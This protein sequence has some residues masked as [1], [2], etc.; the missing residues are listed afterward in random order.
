MMLK[1]CFKGNCKNKLKDNKKFVFNSIFNF[2]TVNA[3]KL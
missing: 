3:S 1:K 2:K